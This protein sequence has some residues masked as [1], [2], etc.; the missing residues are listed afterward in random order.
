[1]KNKIIV[2]LF[3]LIS[4]M[5]SSLF[6]DR[7]LERSEIVNIIEH[8]TNN[9]QQRWITQGTIEATLQS[10]NS[11]T[12]H[13]TESNEIIR[14]DGNKF[15]WEINIISDKLDKRQNNSESPDEK[16]TYLNTK[17]IFTWDGQWYNMYFVPAKHAISTQN[18]TDISPTITGC[19]TAGIIPWGNGI[20]SYNNLLSSELEA[21]EIESNE[22]KLIHLTIK[23]L[24]GIELLL[25][26]DPT[27]DYAAMSSS[28]K[29]SGN[30]CI[31][32]EYSNHILTNGRWIPS[33]ILIERYTDCLK[34]KRL[35]SYDYWTF[36]RISTDKPAET[37]F[38]AA[39]ENNTLI[40]YRPSSNN[41][42]LFCQYSS[43]IDTKSLLDKKLTALKNS[44]EYRQNCAT[45][46]LKY[47]I[48][49]F[50]KYI[51]DS[52]FAVLVNKSDG[53]T[54]LLT[55]Q[56]YSKSVGLQ[57]LAARID[58][59]LLNNTADCK[60]ILYLPW[61]N[62]YVVFSHIENN[63]VWVI[64]MTNNKFCYSIPI[65][66]FSSKEAKANCV[67]LFI[68]NKAISIN[69]TFAEISNDELAGIIGSAISAIGEYSCT[70]LIQSYNVQFCTEPIGIICMG[71][72]RVWFNRYG[73]KEDVN[74]GECTGTSLLGNVFSPCVEDPYYPGNCDITG[75]WYG[76][77]IHACK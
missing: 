15:Y 46:A 8:L 29:D 51:T 33:T 14:Y 73:C 16:D 39:Y 62:H 66:K 40:E 30:S 38:N 18:L 44:G 59:Q 6:A 2:A 53:G 50:S 26:L 47:A 19:L 3:I 67:V 11:I 34:S 43:R 75:I 22:Q 7:V 74:G 64:D 37:T 56:Q 61:N 31:Q 69:G 54:S 58:V 10:F 24:N 48:E 5:T 42:S 70:D 45:S 57:S 68:S 27:K 60:A 25:V 1:M 35:I 23:N 20:Y 49:S 52:D 21:K 77:N 4:T 63:N 9:P 71:E 17:R 13:T 76:Q 36:N 41:G 32:Q 12:N 55:M 28:I 72:Y 65:E